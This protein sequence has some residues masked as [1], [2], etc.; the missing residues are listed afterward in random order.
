VDFRI[1]LLLPSIEQDAN[2]QKKGGQN[3]FAEIYLYHLSF[4]GADK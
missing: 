2:R 4:S 1:D 3:I